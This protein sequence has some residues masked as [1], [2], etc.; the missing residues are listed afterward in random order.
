[1]STKYYLAM[2]IVL[3]LAMG[4][5]LPM[6]M[7]DDSNGDPDA[8]EIA[9]YEDLQAIGSDGQHPID[10]SY[11]LTDD[12]N[13]TDKGEFKPIGNM[14]SNPKKMM[15]TGTFDG[16]DHKIIGL[17]TSTVGIT[18]SL[19]GLF[20]LL[21]PNAVVKDLTLT[22]GEST[23][24][25]GKF[26]MGA[27]AGGIAGMAWAMGTGDITIT[28][29][30]NE[31]TVT[32]T[33]EADKGAMGNYETLAN[34]SAGGIVGYAFEEEYTFEGEYTINISDCTNTGDVTA[35][36][37]TK[38]SW[39]TDPLR[40]G[41][42]SAV[43]IVS[44]GGIVGN[45]SIDSQ[46]SIRNCTNDGNVTAEANA[47]MNVDTGVTDNDMW[48]DKVQ[49]VR[50]YSTANAN[51]GGIVGL[52][53]E[54]S[55]HIL[56]KK[57][58]ILTMENCTNNGN[59]NS[60]A[61]AKTN[62]TI[63]VDKDLAGEYENK[64]GILEVTKVEELKVDIYSNAT[65]SSGGI[66]GYMKQNETANI[67][68]CGNTGK[69]DSSSDTN[70]Q[71]TADVAPGLEMN[72]TVSKIAGSAAASG[73]TIGYL[74]VG[75]QTTAPGT[76]SVFDSYNKGDTS[77]D[78]ACTAEDS[79]TDLMSY[80]GGMI[81]YVE[82]DNGELSIGECFNEGNISALEPSVG[83]N[84]T[85]D[86]RVGEGGLIGGAGLINSNMTF[87]DCYNV[88]DVSYSADVGDMTDDIGGIIGYLNTENSSTVVENC[89]NEGQ[90]G[91][92][93][94]SNGTGTSIG[95]ITGLI[96]SNDLG[97]G[98]EYKNVNCY[99]LEDKG[100]SKLIGNID[101]DTTDP[102]G[103]RT[104]EQMRSEDTSTNGGTFDNWDFDTVW[105]IYPELNDGY[106]ILE[107][108]KDFV[109]KTTYTVTI[110]TGDGGETD[111][112]AG[113]YEAEYDGSFTISMTADTGY[114]IG[115]VLVDGVSDAD[116]IAAG[117]LTLSNILSDKKVEV[118]FE[119][120]YY[121]EV[122]ADEGGTAQ[123]SGHYDKGTTANISAT[124]NDG[125]SFSKW[126]N[127]DR[128]ATT[129]VV[130]N[131]DMTVTAY[132]TKNGGG[133]G[134]VDQ[135]DLKVLADEGGT[136]QGS[137]QYDK[138]TEVTISAVPDEGYKFSNWSNGDRSAVTTVV[139]NG[140]MTV[141][142]HF[143]KD[144]G[145]GGAD[146]YYLEVLA[147][148]GGT[149]AGSG[150]FDKGTVANISATPDDGYVFSHWS[151]GDK[152]ATTTVVVNDNMTVTAYFVKEGDT[153]GSGGDNGGNGGGN[154]GN[155]GKGN[156]DWSPLNLI[157]AII[158][159]MAGILALLSG[160]G[161]DGEEKSKAAL[162][163]RVISLLVGAGAVV[164]FFLTQ[165]WSMPVE[166]INDWTIWMALLMAISIVLAAVSYRFQN[167]KNRP[168]E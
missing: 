20:G 89:Y 28:N 157:A 119:K 97:Q 133:S 37:A 131:D 116:A 9:T 88:G 90:L 45:F 4:A 70:N 76:V 17:K 115:D 13:A 44:A 41:T 47:E 24:V 112:A 117:S 39:V 85:A 58:K 84:P 161:R 50:V 16:D 80:T 51:A 138:G 130:V 12:I 106:P 66:C 158:A 23:A 65:S 22:G 59:V 87:K 49:G 102:Q 8:I 160:R 56:D 107:P 151:N 108:L 153:G 78:V 10:G 140:N 146:K 129:T 120:Q 15:F 144:E 30:H 63:A 110:I 33:A 96:D 162:A 150:H 32:A 64:D 2:G 159:V 128:S 124:A 137:G 11:I 136:A 148:E 139:V 86:I 132:F 141:T 40:M 99:Y 42:K 57:D 36:G 93:S 81:G 164:L 156:G 21:G 55:N 135:Y 54:N 104:S 7:S 43:S 118:T 35:H 69:V 5:M 67:T 92:A 167:R 163:F 155:G 29:C 168:V 83:S 95:G 38:S 123:G 18:A 26:S 113:Q 105:G 34:A 121:L 82:G 127:G 53:D 109:R 94:G 91:D 154:N 3:M 103:M 46:P 142:A 125:Y 152:S 126:S 25:Q 100:A 6:Y 61:N 149:A 14:S 122:L 1:M 165:D 98:S 48:P 31:N 134:G 166:P 79:A 68:Q 62:A 143:I 101:D 147:D 114:V 27:Y 77:T 72:V 71:G 60:D 74:Y 52:I 19:S 111:P 73:G 75:A 145:I